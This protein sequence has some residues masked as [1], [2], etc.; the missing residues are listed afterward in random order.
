MAFEKINYA[1]VDLVFKEQRKKKKK[2]QN[3]R[4][5]ALTLVIIIETFIW[6]RVL[7]LEELLLFCIC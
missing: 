1:N 4:A 7:Q 6:V 5:S 2:E 3:A